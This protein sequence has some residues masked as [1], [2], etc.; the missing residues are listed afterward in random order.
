LQY[1]ISVLF[2]HINP[3]YHVPHPQGYK[4]LLTW[5]QAGEIYRLAKEFTDLYLDIYRDSRL[6][7]H[8]NDSGRSVQRNIEEGYKRNNTSDYLAFLR[9][10]HA[11]NEELK[12]DLEE[13][14]R[15]LEENQRWD[16]EDIRKYKDADKEGR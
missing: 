5:E 6:V 4:Q 14:K 16:K 9:F 3:C 15:E 10:S 11:S 13:L 7:G 8:I 12:R 1:L 2:I